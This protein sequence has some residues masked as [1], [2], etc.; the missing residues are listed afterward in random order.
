MLQA[1][2]CSVNIIPGNSISP[3][4]RIVI[5]STT[6]NDKR[7]LSAFQVSILRVMTPC[8]K[9][10]WHP[11]AS[12]SPDVISSVKKVVVVRKWC[13]RCSWWFRSVVRSH[14]ILVRVLHTCFGSP[15]EMSVGPE[16]KSQ[17]SKVRRSRSTLGLVLRTALRLSTYISTEQHINHEGFGQIVWY[18]KLKKV[19]WTGSGLN[20]TGL[21][22]C[23]LTW[24][25]SRS[26]YPIPLRPMIFSSTTTRSR[27]TAWRGST[28]HTLRVFHTRHSFPCMIFHTW[29]PCI[30]CIPCT[31][32]VLRT[33]FPICCIHPMYFSLVPYYPTCP[34]LRFCRLPG[35]P[36]DLVRW[37]G[38]GLRR[39]HGEGPG[40]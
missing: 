27:L 28:F 13:M 3:H 24:Y 32:I 14:I 15:G 23:S 5:V 16:A 38:E 7:D 29:H 34:I 20:T 31:S 18:R 10:A 1:I 30:P 2:A 33:L 40:R 12:F 21:R 9:E 22:R 39:G 19:V 35:Q 37:H 11:R 6:A 36:R 25:M 26:I 8:R 4:Y 17:L